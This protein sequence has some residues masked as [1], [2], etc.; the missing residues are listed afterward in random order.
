MAFRSMVT[1]AECSTSSNPLSQIVK[2][3][4]GDLSLIKDS[5]IHSTS[6]AGSSSVSVKSNISHECIY[7]YAT[8]GD[9]TTNLFEIK[10]RTAKPD[11][12]IQDDKFAQQFF[13]QRDYPPLPSAMPHIPNI[14]DPRANDWISD[15]GNFRHDPNL[16]SLEA[17]E[18][19]EM[20]LAFKRMNTHDNWNTEFLQNPGISITPFMEMPP[21]FEEAFEKNFNIT[22]DK[23]KGKEKIFEIDSQ[24]WEEQFKAV[25]READD[26]QK[27][28][29]DDAEDK[30]YFYEFEKIWASKNNIN[31]L[32]NISWEEGFYKYLNE[33]RDLSFEEYEFE[34]YEFESN[35]IFLDH[36]D[37]LHEG[38]KLMENGGS[39]SEAALAF[40]M[41]VQKDNND[42]DAW[43]LL[44]NTQA[45]NEK[46]EAAIKALEKSVELNGSNLPALMSLA[47][48]YTNDRRDYEACLTL[49]RW[50]AIKYPDVVTAAVP[51]DRTVDTHTRVTDLFLQAA[52]SA[53][54]GQEMD[55]DVQVGLGV[56]YYSGGEHEKAIDCFLSALN[57]RKDDYQLWNRL[58]ATL[59]NSGR[60]EDAIE[61][62]YKALELK[63]TYVRARFN[64]GVSCLNIK[65]YRE[66]AEHLLGA[67]SMHHVGTNSDGM[68]NASVSLREIL[69]KAFQLM[70]RD[71]LCEK[72]KN[73]ADAEQFRD[74]FEF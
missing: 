19:A 16:W 57:V 36:P 66:A 41:A 58:G 40:E 61:A 70:G 14:V 3:A 12:N 64:L 15:F 65:C 8:F 2:Q 26:A 45:Q 23:G 34:E 37:P 39:L 4:N 32:T 42:S 74:E 7:V 52:R 13:D 35:N 62:Y 68:K 6:R 44:G 30:G 48:S 17:A 25:L 60:S 53:P 59:A 71:D 51:M 1:G 20:E 56:L 27:T 5:Y 54:E 33:G 55:P 43:M 18:E 9:L 63:P 69:A 31:D 29:D 28:T 38:L 46:E 50:L 21:E 24:S 47:V 11:T 22:N 49:E 73:G 10:F 67:L 72:L